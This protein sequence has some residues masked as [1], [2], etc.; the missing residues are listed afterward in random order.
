MSNSD[1]R[2]TI[3]NAIITNTRTKIVFGGL[4]PDDADF[5]ARVLFSGHLNLEEWKEGSAR[6]T[7]VG[8]K[9]EIVRGVSRA[10]NEARH[11]THTLTRSQS[12][13]E[14]VGSMTGTS[15]GTGDFSASGDSAGMVM[16]PP[17]QLL[18]PN[19]PNAAAIPYA[20]SQTTGEA[21]SRGSSKQQAVSTAN[22]RTRITVNAE[23]EALGFGT[24][25]GTSV[26]ES[27]N[28]TFVT[29]YAV[30]PTQMFSLPEQQHRAAGALMTLALRECYVKLGNAAP[31]KTRTADLEP[32]FKSSYFRRLWVPMFHANRLRRSH[33]LLPASEVD[34]L[35]ASR[36][37]QPPEPPQLPEPDFSAPEPMPIVDAPEAFA[38]RFWTKRTIPG[39][40]DEPPKPKPRPKKPRG[41]RPIG[42]L[43]P[44]H[45]RFRVIDGGEKRK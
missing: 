45:D 33:Y 14:A 5:M 26:S 35:I 6:P 34:A 16:T 13:G 42:D 27:E 29:E 4:A 22:S 19:A 39:P 12:S 11:E 36:L 28:E 8:N 24:S 40:D 18:G 17:L 9:K 3:L 1:D 30:L 23:A 41:R 2:A 7:A 32:A 43:K 38:A 21:N 37:D 10:E 31:V 44:A 15:T 20:L 25:R